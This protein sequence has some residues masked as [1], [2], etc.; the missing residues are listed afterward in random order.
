MSLGRPIGRIGLQS[1]GDLPC[2]RGVAA[3]HIAVV[4]EPPV[5]WP[6]SCGGMGEGGAVA[7]VI[8]QRAAVGVSVVRSRHCRTDPP[9]NRFGLRQ[10]P[11]S[12]VGRSEF[13]RRPAADAIV[14]PRQP[15][16][17]G[18]GG[19]LDEV[20]RSAD[21]VTDEGRVG[22]IHLDRSQRR[23]DVVEVPEQGGAVGRGSAAGAVDD[24]CEV[25]AAS[26][27]NTLCPVDECAIEII[28]RH[29]ID[30]GLQG[31][32]TANEEQGHTGCA[33]GFDEQAR[34]LQPGAV[35][36][37][38]IADDAGGRH[39]RHRFGNRAK[40]ARPTGAGDMSGKLEQRPT[41]RNEPQRSR[42][43]RDTDP[44]SACYRLLERDSTGHSTESAGAVTAGEV[45]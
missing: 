9:E 30:I 32:E 22:R 1:V 36:V 2:L 28:D 3:T 35:R 7:Q 44:L 45:V 11:Q 17:T 4:R 13:L 43:A 15:L 12:I 40:L 5:R 26:C 23:A 42:R 33:G 31:I 16:P 8:D 37:F 18:V 20:G 38:R 29:M 14:G 19:G 34:S 6:E 25:T 27:G 24:D 10:R 21:V 41:C 39:I